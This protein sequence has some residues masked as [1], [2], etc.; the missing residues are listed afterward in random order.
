MVNAADAIACC[1]DLYL[2]S[3]NC[4]GGG[5]GSWKGSGV[6]AT[7]PEA[8]ASVGG[9]GRGAPHSNGNIAS[10]PRHR[11]SRPVPGRASDA[12]MTSCKRMREG[13]DTARAAAMSNGSVGGVLTGMHAACGCVVE[14]AASRR[15]AAGGHSKRVGSGEDAGR[16]YVT[17]GHAGGACDGWKP[18]RGDQR[19]QTGAGGGRGGRGVP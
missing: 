9:G 1:I 2:S 5:G 11:N 14:T 7:V 4:I 18:Y 6:G 8:E 12:G 3:L 17:E 10:I 15:V 13:G 16:V 19:R